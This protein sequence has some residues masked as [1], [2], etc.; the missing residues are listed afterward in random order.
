MLGFT[1]RR[2]KLYKIALSHRSIKDGAHENNER[3]EFLG[4]AVLSAAVAHYLFNK[5]PYKDE[6]FLTEMRSKMV[7]RQMLNA[8][9]IK[10][11]LKSVC[12]Y[13]K[14]DNSLRTS[15]IFGNV[16][17]AIIGAV[18]LEK[19]YIKTQDW[20]LK[21]IINP[22][23]FIEELEVIDIN[24]KN[25][26][27]GWA[28]KN[29]KLLEFITVGEEVENGRR[30]FTIAAQVNGEIIAESKAYTKKMASQQATVKAL[31]QLGL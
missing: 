23:M 21:R 5:Y 15:Q 7:N 19:G 1:P 27:Y 28:N 13:N 10:M 30:L 18:Y 31:E 14:V 22:L 26:L 8:I 25:K 9:A 16:L 2:M 4:D 11:G 20:L 12:L 29:G 17:E 3:L 6:G 24:L